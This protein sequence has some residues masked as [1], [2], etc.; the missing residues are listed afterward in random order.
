L[1]PSA[2]SL[3]NIGRREN[4]RRAATLSPLLGNIGAKKFL[5]CTVHCML[6]GVIKARR[7]RWTE[8]RRGN[9]GKEWAFH[10]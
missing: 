10:T 7:I 3:S 5:V 4:Y 6:L 2:H 1:P 9:Y 8:G